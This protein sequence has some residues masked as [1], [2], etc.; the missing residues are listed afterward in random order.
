MKSSLVCI[1]IVNW[2]GGQKII[3][4][5]KSLKK[6]SYK[7]YKVIL[8][9]NGSEDES[10]KSL[11][12]INRKIDVIYLPKNFGYTIAMNLGWKHALKK[13]NADY[14]CAMDSDIITIQ[15]DWLDVQIKE[16]EKDDRYGI[17]GGKLVFPDNRLQLLYLERVTNNYSEKDNGQYDFIKETKAVG[18]AC[19][20]IKSDVIKNIGYYDE[21]FFYGPNDIDYCLRA[22]KDKPYEVLSHCGDILKGNVYGFKTLY[23]GFSKSIHNG[24][25]SYLATDNTKI[26]EAQSKGN[27][28]FVFRHYGGIAG[29][30]MICRQFVRVFVTRKKPFEPITFSNLNVHKQFFKRFGLFIKSI[31]DSLDYNA[32]KKGN[33]ERFIQ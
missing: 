3:D 30:K 9:D 8:V 23:N 21:N 11:K 12:K 28:L 6:T 25:S 19:I 4:C 10:V 32:I 7:N 29:F 18:G 20:I 2:N 1:V 14:I 24:S 22:G 26:F 16:L 15:N 13:Y 27:I 31:R 17:S 5:L 33:Y